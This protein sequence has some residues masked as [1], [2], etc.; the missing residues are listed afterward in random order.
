MK[1]NFQFN[2][3]IF[4]LNLFNAWLKLDTNTYGCIEVINRHHHDH[5]I[6]IVVITSYHR[7]HDRNDTVS[8]SHPF[9]IFVITS[10]SWSSHRIV[11]VVTTSY[12]RHH[13]ASSS[14][15]SHLFVIVAVVIIVRPCHDIVSSS[16][17]SSLHRICIIY[18]SFSPIAI[19]VHCLFCSAAMSSTHPLASYPVTEH[20][21]RGVDA[22]TCPIQMQVSMLFVLAFEEF[23]SSFELRS[24]SSSIRYVW[25]KLWP[26]PFNSEN[27]FT[28]KSLSPKKF[29]DR[30][31][32]LKMLIQTSCSTT[33]ARSN[34]CS[35]WCMNSSPRTV[36]TKMWPMA[37]TRSGLKAWITSNWWTVWP[38]L[39]AK[40]GKINCC[41]QIHFN[42]AVL[43][44]DYFQLAVY[45]LKMLVLFHQVYFEACHSR[46]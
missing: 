9:I 42:S 24:L 11:M 4:E 33:E 32:I 12:H 35:A 16:S 10:S 45:L 6:I 46:V 8:S 18:I 39:A 19:D 2:Q 40:K 23:L 3:K 21:N 7:R 29:K 28:C 30:Y 5:R 31:R 22:L 38:M 25:V 17:S 27:C 26:V 1:P 44:I 34:P 43:R 13:I 20:S 37:R 36:P 15:L 14:S 41:N